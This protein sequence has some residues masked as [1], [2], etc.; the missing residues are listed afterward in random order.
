MRSA[1][2]IALV[3]IVVLIGGYAF[4]TG[5]SPR[6]EAPVWL[7]AQRVSHRGMWADG[8]ARP[9]NSLAAFEAAAAAGFAVELDVH[10]SADGVT[11]VVHDSELERMTGADVL[12]E[13]LTLDELKELRLLG[14]V[15]RIPTLEEA[16]ALVDGRVPVFVE[17]KNEGE[18]GALEDDVAAQLT[19][20]SGDACVM[21]FNPYSLARVAEAEPD[22][23]RG[24]LASRFKGEDL[25]WY[26]KLLLANMMMNWTSKPDFIAYDIDAL[27]CPGVTVQTWRGR[28]ILGWTI[29]NADELA[30]AESYCD[31]FIC[32]PGALEE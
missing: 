28:P 18:V 14:G 19:A 24:Q 1:A 9:E 30:Y 10:S 12:V 11:V 7:I 20:Y 3:V 31:G 5:G 2:W 15:E 32:N 22:I 6:R 4:A 23:T 26:Q 25:P 8:S 16:L 13:D 29:D 17:I 21:S 27:P